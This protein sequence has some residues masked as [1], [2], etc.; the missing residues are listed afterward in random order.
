MTLRE[1]CLEMHRRMHRDAMLRQGSP[2]DDL[3]D[4]V[5]AE[6][7]RAAEDRLDES[8]PLCIYFKTE[9]DREEF[10][11]AFHKAKPGLITKRLP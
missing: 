10:I 3:V 9:G 8:L 11:D 5:V 4:F 6:R 7:G 2:V 1:R